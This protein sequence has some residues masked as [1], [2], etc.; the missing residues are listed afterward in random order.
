VPANWTYIALPD[1]IPDIA[2]APVRN[3]PGRVRAPKATG[4]IRPVP[5][6]AAAGAPSVMRE[7]GRVRNKACHYTPGATEHVKVGPD[8]GDD[9][10]AVETGPQ[11]VW[12][13]AMRVVPLSA[14]VEMLPARVR[15]VAGLRLALSRSRGRDGDLMEPSERNALLV[16]KQHAEKELPSLRH[17]NHLHHIIFGKETVNLLL[18]KTRVKND[19]AD[20]TETGSEVGGGAAATADEPISSDAAE[21]VVGGGTFRLLQSAAG[22]LVRSASLQGA[23]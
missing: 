3:P 23:D 14:T 8:S 17:G 13:S 1:K 6:V 16:Y 12:S 22:P 7:G 4:I 9:A 20:P 19:L 18:W 5:S 2:V 11:D 10:D 21:V 15:V